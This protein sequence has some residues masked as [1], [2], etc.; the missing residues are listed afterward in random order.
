MSARMSTVL[1]LATTLLTGPASH[2]QNR[3]PEPGKIDLEAAEI[4]AELIGGPVLAI[5]G[6][7]VGRVADVWLDE[8][9]QPA[10]LRI[11]TA[12]RLGLGARVVEIPP[13]AFTAMRGAVVLDMPADAVGLLPELS[14]QPKG[15]E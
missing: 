5:D 10:R 2:A 11:T 15:D 8:E 6:T 14:D 13:G 3:D 9:G 7:E 12:A 4:V 1:A